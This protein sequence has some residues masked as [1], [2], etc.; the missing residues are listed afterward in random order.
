LA[1]A[2]VANA[3]SDSAQ[4]AEQNPQPVSGANSNASEIASR[5][6][7]GTL[8]VRVNLVLV[9]AVVRDAQG[10]AVGN[11]QKEDFQLF[12]KGKPQSI[13]QFSVE[14]AGAQPLIANKPSGENTSEP[15]RQK[16][17]P[18]VIPA[19]YVAYLF[20]DMHLEF[21]DLIGVRDAAA[22]H[23]ATALQA[24][25]RAA[26][27]TTSGQT[28]V[29]FTDDRAKLADALQRIRPQAAQNSA[30][31]E[32]PHLD[33]Y[34]ADLIQ[35]KNDA[36][37]L[38]V[39]TQDMMSCQPGINSTVAAGMVSSAALR[40]SEAGN[41]QTR[42][43]LG[44]VQDLVRRVG[45]LPGERSIIL[46]SPGFFAPESQ[47]DLIE[48]VDRALRS[49]VMISTLDAR[50]LYTDSAYDA[51]QQN[52]VSPQ[53]I[54]LFLSYQ[55]AAASADADVLAELADGTGG[56]FFHNNNDLVG[57]FRRVAAA[58]EF[59]YVLG[60]T[61]QNL[62]LDGTFHALKVSVNTKE[63]PSVQSRRGYYAP[64]HAED[65]VE[66]A[67]EE[68]EALLFSQMEMH[69]VPFQLRTQFFKADDFNVKLAVIAHV[70]IS[71]MTFAKSDG[72]NRNGL[73]F[74]TGLFDRNGNFVTGIEQALEMRFLDATLAARMRSGITLRT[75]FDVK[76]GA[77]VVRMAVRDTQGQMMSAE[78]KLVDIPQ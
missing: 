13:S 68:I 11:L 18:F 9:R 44:V 50:G 49:N 12:D 30:G 66:A 78:N 2:P 1:R 21:R 71:H 53:M 40:I 6:V 31:Q 60:F 63:K 72:R 54:V 76:P 22:R 26:I 70:D 16:N 73:T 64:R 3:Q 27:F 52:S 67:R 69:D 20:D 28:V 17:P 34:M 33:Y 58:P 25:D 19:R 47:Q 45:M 55:S 14:K 62:K 51:S 29:D 39:A 15:G 57:G 38:S 43:C 4:P 59:L 41:H 37:A 46:V 75:N 56:T 8:K 74:A 61:P 5:V 65:P 32:C 77:Y 36:Q 48:I 35:N 42:V 24:A 10:R 23:L 7:P